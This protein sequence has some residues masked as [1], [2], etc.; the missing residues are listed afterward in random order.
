MENEKHWMTPTI[1]REVELA[2]GVTMRLIEIEMEAFGDGLWNEPENPKGRWALSIDGEVKRTVTETENYICNWLQNELLDDGYSRAEAEKMVLILR[3]SGNGQG[4]DEAAKKLAKIIYEEGGALKYMCESCARVHVGDEIAIRAMFLSYAGTRVLNAEVGIHIALCGNPGTGKSH[5]TNTVS[6]HIPASAVC[7]SGFSD[8]AL[9]YHSFKERTVLILDDQELSED[10]Q[11]L[12]KKA[13][14]SWRQE[15]KFHTV[16]NQQGLVLTMPKRC[17]FWVVKANMTGDDQV[18]DRQ[19]VI[20]TDD[21]VEQM[22]RIHTAIKQ[23]AM[24]HI[25]DENIGS[26]QV[27]RYIWELIGDAYVICDY[28]MCVLNSDEMSPRNCKLMYALI[29]AHA[30][31][32]APRRRKR[33]GAILANIEDFKAAC[34]IMNPLLENNGGSQ[35]LK[36]TPN[37][38]K[39]LDHLRTMSSGTI[40]FRDIRFRTGMSS[41]QLAEALYGRSDVEG[42]HGLI[43]VCPAVGVCKHSYMADG[44][45]SSGKAVEWDAELA[46]K[47]GGTSGIFEMKQ[48]DIEK[49]QYLS[50]LDGES[51]ESPDDFP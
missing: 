33:E 10:F 14:T 23:N 24:G 6:N 46:R 5:T 35:N 30:V 4:A 15:A 44:E 27:S 8:K 32:H 51:P 39:L 11:E 1:P 49:Y 16:R 43:G 50:V 3:M 25:V 34:R 12:V 22:R 48:E 41:R 26:A 20:W 18:L 17:P 38:A 21:S 13:T 40:T 9:L 7:N 37:A 47:W 28:A 31:M 45:S 42:S 36:L 19:L 29:C 2:P